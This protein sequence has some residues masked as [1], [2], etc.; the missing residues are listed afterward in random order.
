MSLNCRTLIIFFNRAGSLCCLSI[1]R[2]KYGAQ[3]WKYQSCC[4]WNDEWWRMCRRD[5]RYEQKMR[6]QKEIFSSLL[7]HD[8]LC[9][10]LA[11]YCVHNQAVP[12]LCWLPVDHKQELYIGISIV[13]RNYTETMFSLA[14]RRVAANVAKTPAFATFRFMSSVPSTMKVS[15]DELV[16]D[17]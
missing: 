6:K 12:H 4:L 3:K 5:L 13:W 15:F 7:D 14:S 2:W 11:A 8:F 16:W 17:L 9:M 1:D 10:H